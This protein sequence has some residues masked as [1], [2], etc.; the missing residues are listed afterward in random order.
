MQCCWHH[1]RGAH[2]HTRTKPAEFLH[3]MSI[4]TAPIKRDFSTKVD[5]ALRVFG[6]EETRV[7]LGDRT[8]SDK[9]EH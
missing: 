7:R 3:Q 1:D 9:F 6:L 2:T 8:V 4:G 5:T